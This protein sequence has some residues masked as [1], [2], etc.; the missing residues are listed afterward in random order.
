MIVQ[1]IARGNRMLAAVLSVVIL[2]S[3]AAL[4]GRG[5]VTAQRPDTPT[6]TPTPT[7][8]PTPSPTPVPCPLRQTCDTPT[9]TATAAVTATS[10]S[11]PTPQVT[12]TPTATPTVGIPTVPAGATLHPGDVGVAAQDLPLAGSP[13]QNALTTTFSSWFDTRA[14]PKVS[15]F[16]LSSSQPP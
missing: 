9:P 5:S 4:I 14:C 3:V 8:T 13:N 7:V 2:V 6:P 1:R 10:T 12:A 15:V 11:T 16:A